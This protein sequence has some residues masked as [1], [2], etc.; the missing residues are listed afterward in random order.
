MHH[1]YHYLALAGGALFLYFISHFLRLIIRLHLSP[2][3]SLRGPPAASFLLGNLKAMH[4]QANNNIIARWEAIY[5]PAF[6][7]KGIFGGCRLITTDPLAISYVLTNHKKYPKPEFI[8]ENLASMGAGQY[9]VLTVEGEDHDRQRKILA[10]AFTTSQIKSLT[11]IFWQK[12]YEVRDVW[13]KSI[14]EADAAEASR[15]DV[16]AWLSKAALDVIGLAGFGYSFDALAKDD[17]ELASA[18]NVI[19]TTSQKFRTAAILQLWFPLLRIFRRHN[20]LMKHAHSILDRIGLELVE[21]RK[22]EVAAELDNASR[23]DGKANSQ[24]PFPANVKALPRDLLSVLI[25]SNLASTPSDRM[26]I[27]EVLCQISTFTLAG[28]ETTSFALTWCLYALAQSPDCQ[29]KLR[30]ELHTISRGSPSFDEEVANLRYLDWVV[31]E[32]LRL[33]A[34]VVCT[35]RVAM[36]EDEIPVLASF[37]DKSGT[38]RS[39]IKVNKHDLVALPIQTVNKS[40]AIWGEDAH[41]FRPERWEKPPKE[42]KAIQGLYSNILTFLSGSRGCIGYKF[43]VTEIKIFLYALLHDLEFSIDPSIIIEKTF[44]V[45]ARPSVKSEPDAGN[46]MPLS[47]S[48]VSVLPTDS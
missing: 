43:A 47:I 28:H 32:T 46:Q 18:Y 23:L 27:S 16:C 11:P 35:M 14:Q 26:N 41:V 15:I 7:Y 17:N 36:Q 4:D 3:R 39:S 9:S 29:K 42:A 48:L 45:V 30:A 21:E 13:M 19:F 10:P 12:A 44:N 38:S 8:R 31:R 2:L 33:H 6:A 34:P 22:K 1:I 37:T 20:T 24:A 25:R 40:S 5:G